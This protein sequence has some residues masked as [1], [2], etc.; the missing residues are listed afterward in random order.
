MLERTA[1]GGTEIS[2]AMARLP[3][4]HFHPLPDP[5]R[6]DEE[7]LRREIA[8]VSRHPVVEALLAAVDAALLVLNEERQ[9]VAFNSRVA[10]LTSPDILGLRPGEAFGCVNAQTIAGCGAVPA[11][12]WCGT[13]GAF[14]ASHERGHAAEAETSMRRV[15]GGVL[16]LN[17]RATPVLVEGTGFTVVSL[18][19]ISAEKHRETLEQIFFHDVLNTITGLRGWAELLKASR[20][21]HPEAAD[22]IHR[23]S[24]S[25]EREIRDHRA[26]VMAERGTLV[27]HAERVSVGRVMGELEGVFASQFASRG[28]HLQLSA[29]GEVEFDSD[30]ALLLRVLVNMVQNALEASAQGGTVR[31]RLERLSPADAG[32]GALRF[33]VWN[34]AVMP[35][36]VQERVFARSFSTKARQGRGLGTYSMKLLGEQA[37]G[38]RVGFASDAGA[39]TLFFLDLPLAS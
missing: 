38:G 36:E 11:C 26:I 31:V 21:A 9:V 23:L 35:R 33:S 29:D 19:D 39:G 12:Q 7:R 15:S 6:A 34:E 18:R 5:R 1:A 30:P 37:L 8:T 14:L 27:A 25:I 24:G 13:L 4:G 22:R 3:P 28:R 17:V 16:E 10:A 2:D 20:G 32:G